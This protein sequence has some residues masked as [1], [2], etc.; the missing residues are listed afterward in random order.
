[1]QGAK[2]KT[3]NHA[4]DLIAQYV[5]NDKIQ[6]LLA[7][8]TLY[9]GIDPKRG[10]SLYSIIPMIEMMFG[11]HFIKGGMYGMAQGL[12]RLNQDLGVDI[13]LNAQIDEIIIDP[14]YKRADGI[15]VNGLVERF[16]KVLCTAD[17]PYAAQ[18]LM[19]EHSP[20]KKYPPQ[21]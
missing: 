5:D 21:K 7:F 17:F 20:V 18:H 12:T 11:V 10:P 8:Q 4:D 6:K 16:D 15:R 9:I 1:M 2:L 14:K 19:P 3:L 13:R